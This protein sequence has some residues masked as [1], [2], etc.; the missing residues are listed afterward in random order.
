MK[1][2]LVRH[3]K[4]Q[5]NLEGRFQGA[6]GDSPLLEEAIEELEELGQYLS[7]IH[8]DAVYSS[9][10]GR[11]RD[12]VNIL[13]NANS[14]P[15]EIHYTPQLREWALGTLEGCKIATMQAIYPRQMTA[16]YQNPLQFKHDMF[17]A[18][19]LYQTT[20][21]VESFLRSLASK[22]YDKVL[23][24]G[25]GANLTASIRS[26]L[27]YQYGSLHYKDKLDNAS[28]TIIETHDFKDFNCLT[29]ND[30]SYLRQ[31]V[32]MTH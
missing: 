25:H 21:R 18:E 14:C 23:I 2:Y 1:F 26:L 17:G 22:N 27:G 9:D 4:T 15:K 32:K 20:H 31:E 11:A 24:V 10:L 5:W 7:S 28:L 30:K 6:N 3:G 16:F 8:F 29:W 13:N 12:T 19:S